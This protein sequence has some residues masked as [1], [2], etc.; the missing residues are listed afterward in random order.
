MQLQ[1]SIPSKTKISSQK[2][3]RSE[4]RVLVLV[5]YLDLDLV[6]TQV[7]IF[8]IWPPISQM[9]LHPHVFLSTE[10]LVFVLQES[11]IILLLQ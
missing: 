4:N 6:K 7:N 3:M 10:T 11:S 1:L 2:C 8:G 5:V 9:V